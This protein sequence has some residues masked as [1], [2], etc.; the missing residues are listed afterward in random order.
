[1]IEKTARKP[2]ADPAQEKL[3]QNKAAWNKEVSRLVNDI[4]HL[5]KMMNGWPSKFFKERSRITE[6]IPAD[7]AT[8]IG[9]LAND[10]QELA[11]RGQGI[12]QEQLNYSKTRRQKQ[13][14]SPSPSQETPAVPT[15]T[16]AP[17]APSAPDLTK[18]LAAWEQKYAYNLISEASNPITRFI[19]R[20]LTPTIGFGEAARI[21][22]LR[23]T[24]LKA[25]AKTLKQLK[26]LQNEIVKSSTGSIGE[27]HKIM[28]EVANNW[29]VVARGFAAAKSL[30]PEVP[31]DAG[32]EIEP[33]TKEEKE[34]KAEREQQ[35]ALES[36]Q[37]N[38]PVED[39]ST[40]QPETGAS[41]NLDETSLF[42]KEQ[43]KRMIGDFKSNMFEINKLSLGDPIVTGSL[44]E[45]YSAMDK[46]LTTPQTNKISVFPELLS[47]Y[48]KMIRNINAHFH[49]STLTLREMLLQIRESAKNKPPKQ[50]QVARWLGKARHQ[51][52]P[53]SSSGSRLEIYQAIANIRKDLNDIMDWLESGWYPEQ[54]GKGIPDINR[55]V[56]TLRALVRA[57]HY[58]EGPKPKG[59]EIGLFENIF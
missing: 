31:E 16:S 40:T 28:T 27:S 33:E 29:S 57:L 50:A 24:L 51:M 56:M 25:C 42:K 12:V 45:F 49:T 58:T 48:T 15:T 41:V 35:R 9:S 17:V 3:R 38:V 4:I 13:P 7:P 37:G 5:K 32:G 44:T 2:S 23:M 26:R 47:V 54:M 6:P 11:Q 34:E 53:G 46:Y 14:K 30:R 1:M 20:I 19:T 8:I 43:A 21:R 39:V 36:Q 55:Q 18:Q 52:L 10:F 59:K 22:R